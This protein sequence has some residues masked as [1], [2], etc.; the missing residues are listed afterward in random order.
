MDEAR[1]RMYT[2]DVAAALRERTGRLIKPSSIKTRASRSRRWL[3]EHPGAQL[4]AGWLPLPDGYARQGRVDVPWWH[5]ETIARWLPQALAP[6]QH[7]R[8]G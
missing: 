2:A 5:A 3:R 7:A 4:P 8:A 1:E 6:G